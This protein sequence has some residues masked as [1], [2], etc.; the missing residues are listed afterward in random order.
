M[1]IGEHTL[2]WLRI[3]LLQI[4]AEWLEETPNGFRWWPHQQAQTLEVIGQEIGP[5][6]ATV[7]L[8]QV[9]TELLVDLDLDPEALEVLQA[10]ALRTAGM[11]GPV[12]HPERRTLDLCSLVR[13]YAGIEEWMQ[14]LIGMAAVLQLRDAWRGATTMAEVLG[15]RPAV[16]AHPRS[17]PRS[18]PDALIT[19]VLAVLD[20]EGQAPSRWAGEELGQFAGT[21][22][23]RSPSLLGFGDTR[24][25]TVEFPYG[26]DRSSLC[27]VSTEQVHPWYG[28]GLALRQRLP[29]ATETPVA[30]WRLAL[31]LNARALAQAPMGYGFGSFGYDKDTLAF[32]TFL[33]NAVHRRGLIMNLYLSAAERARLLSVLLT[34]VDWTE[35]SFDPQRTAVGRM[36]DGLEED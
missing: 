36:L 22:L 2:D 35:A 9:R 13:I 14:R 3:S 32:Q 21:A 8:V 20:A 1:R 29:V 11:A 26:A 15:A 18:E 27:E 19:E 24:G 10:V 25:F 4:D 28:R 16:S 30:G 5:D 7:D 31:E 6:G 12:Y 17:G 33:P 34:G 23:K